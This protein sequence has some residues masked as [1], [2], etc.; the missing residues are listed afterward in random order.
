M[1]LKIRIIFVT[2]FLLTSI[3]Y[4]KY[5]KYAY[6]RSTTLNLR[7]APSIKSSIIDKLKRKTKVQILLKKGKW[8]KVKVIDKSDEIGWVYYTGLYRF[9]KE[10]VPDYNVNIK[11][12]NFN[13]TFKNKILEFK[14]YLNF[15]FYQS[16]VEVIFSYEKELNKLT[17]FIKTKFSLNYYEQNKDSSIKN[18]EIDLYPYLNFAYVID[19][20]I[21]RVKNKYPACGEFLKKFGI[22]IFLEKD[23]DN[24]I[25]LDIYRKIK[26]YKFSPFIIVKSP[27][28]ALVKITTE[29]KNKLEKSYIFELEPPYYSYGIKS[30]SFLLYEFFNMLKG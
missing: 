9:K 18:N 13:E 5:V 8:Y 23:N 26:L 17:I 15:D 27:G 12:N 20:F 11:F 3:C 1:L 25:I 28:Y 16:D 4:A 22:N 10:Y 2:F 19:N 14:K 29:N 21:K 30:T 7:N 6:V 24:Y